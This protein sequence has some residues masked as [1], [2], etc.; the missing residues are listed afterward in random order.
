MKKNV[1]KSPDADAGD[2][3]GSSGTR[4]ALA[5]D[6]KRADNG[7]D[8]LVG[9]SIAGRLLKRLPG[10]R[11]AES[12]LEALE[13]EVFKRLKT[14]LDSAGEPQAMSVFAVSVSSSEQSRGGMPGDLLRRLLEQSQKPCSKHQAELEYFTRLLQELTPDE[15]RI[16]AALSDGVVYPVIDVLTA[17]KLSVVS[18]PVV[19]SVSTVGKA[20]GVRAPELTPNYVRHLRRMGLV[21]IVPGQVGEQQQYQLLETDSEVRTAMEAARGHGQR[22]HIA[23]RSLR[24]S[25]V[26]ARLWAACRLSGE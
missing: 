8:S 7:G 5:Q 20:A 15:A 10:G 18:R 23:R 16:L 11:F 2:A 26:G 13:S 3:S 12:R 17:S 22:A 4:A 9:S 14:R 21:D 19:E 1:N 6:P 24:I 25:A